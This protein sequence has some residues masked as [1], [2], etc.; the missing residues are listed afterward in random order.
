VDDGGFLTCGEQRSLLAV[1]Q[2]VDQK[3]KA[4]AYNRLGARGTLE[5]PV[6]VCFT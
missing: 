3:L 6:G 2:R 5:L 1:D 4:T